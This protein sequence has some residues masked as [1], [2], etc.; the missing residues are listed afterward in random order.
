[1]SEFI[2]PISECVNANE[3]PRLKSDEKLPRGS[4]LYLRGLLSFGH[5]FSD[6]GKP[7]GMDLPEALLY[8]ESLSPD[9]RDDR[10]SHPGPDYPW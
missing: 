2:L 4:A 9:E 8:I 5:G 7:L 3:A 6:T 1:M 10:M